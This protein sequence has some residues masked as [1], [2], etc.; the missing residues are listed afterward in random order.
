MSHLRNN[1]SW[2][3]HQEKFD[4][5]E[6]FIDHKNIPGYS[7]ESMEGVLETPI[8]NRSFWLLGLVFFAIGIAMFSRIIVL[9][10]VE[11][12]QLR[13]RSD[14]NHLR[15]VAIAPE[16]GLIYDR[17]GN[18]LASN[19]LRED[20]GTKSAYVGNLVG[21]DLSLIRRYPDAG[22][23]HVLGLL[24]KEGVVSQGLNGLEAEYDDILRGSAGSRI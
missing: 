22:F 9:T 24:S 10:G 16:R 4:V 11:G 1:K 21:A 7:Q 19:T 20:P 13:E 12:V 8:K 2:A 17:M 5:D 3:R 14:Q 15:A 6:I 18:V 23:S